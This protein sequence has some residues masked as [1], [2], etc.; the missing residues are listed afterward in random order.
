MGERNTRW[1][2]AAIEKE[3]TRLGRRFG[4]MPT[5]KEMRRVHKGLSGAVAKRGLD[6]WAKK[7]GLRRFESWERQAP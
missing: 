6:Y 4:R 2:D 3:L 1:T 5:N 7:L